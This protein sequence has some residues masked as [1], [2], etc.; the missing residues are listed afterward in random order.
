[1][2]GGKRMRQIILDLLEFSRVGR[3]EDKI[4]IVDL[5]QLVNDIFFLQR[6][7]I[8]DVQAVVTVEK[9]PL[10]STR[11]LPLQQVFQ[12]LL[13]NSLKYHRHGVAPQI[14]ISVIRRGKFWQFA[15]SDNGIGIGEE[16]FERIFII[17]QRLHNKEEYSG[18]GIG[19]SIAK[20]IIEGMGGKI[21]VESVEGKGSTFYFTI[22]KNAAHSKP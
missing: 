21:R 8:E 6:Q 4:E 12:N 13:N 11:K 18:T 2:D 3:T 14:S 9:L 1:M 22:L 20:K 10:V 17:F 19:L 15:I 7:Q 5:N 16:Y